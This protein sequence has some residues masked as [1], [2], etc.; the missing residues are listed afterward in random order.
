MGTLARRPQMYVSN[1]FAPRNVQ[2]LSQYV[3]TERNKKIAS[4]QTDLYNIY[5]ISKGELILQWIKYQTCLFYFIFL[6]LNQVHCLL[7]PSERQGHIFCFSARQTE[8]CVQMD[9]RPLLGLGWT[10]GKSVF[11]YSQHSHISF[12]IYSVSTTQNISNKPAHANIYNKINAL[13]LGW[14]MGSKVVNFDKLFLHQFSNKIYQTL[15]DDV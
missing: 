5:L 2:V 8:Q 3:I 12:L 1:I 10:G 7:D 15:R 6:K 9:F 14:K 13:W 4:A 11:S